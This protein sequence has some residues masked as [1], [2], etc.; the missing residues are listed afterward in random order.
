[1]VVA[2]GLSCSVARWDLSSPTGDRVH[3]PCTG[4]RILNHRTARKV[5]LPQFLKIHTHAL[6]KHADK[7]DQRV[8]LVT[9]KEADKTG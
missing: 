1:M 9:I 2:H 7:Q 3:G 5:P 6:K 4:R 8:V